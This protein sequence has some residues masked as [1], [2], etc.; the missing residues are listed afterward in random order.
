MYSPQVFRKLQDIISTNLSYKAGCFPLGELLLLLKI[1]KSYE[2]EKF[3]PP[4][5]RRK[6]SIVNR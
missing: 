3:I 6:P 4:E 5:I 1:M 2:K